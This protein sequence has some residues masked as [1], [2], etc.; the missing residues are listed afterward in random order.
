MSHDLEIAIDSVK[1]VG[2]MIREKY[3]EE[4]IVMKKGKQDFVTNVDIQAET[5][6]VDCLRDTGYSFFGEERGKMKN[7]SNKTWIVDP[8]DG[9]YNFIHA[10]PF[11]AISLALLEE[12]NDLLLGVVYNPITEEC[13]W[14]EKGSGAYLNGEPVYIRENKNI[15]ESIFL[16]EH[17]SS[18]ESR[19]KYLR[20]M[21]QLILQKDMTVVRQGA[22]ALMLC[23]VARG[24]FDGFLSCGDELYDYAAGLII[25]KE[26]GASICDW[27]GSKWNNTNSYILVTNDALREQI[28]E[29]TK[30][31]Q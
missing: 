22:T 4:K 9:T 23:L 21:S 14:A 3:R 25:A 18:E 24:A 17:G 20:C 6:I 2:K 7:G 5:M 15:H 29:E 19:R 12:E 31:I 26:A 16:M 10:I 1:K 13:Y 11:F 30:Q 27:K 8:I 28:I